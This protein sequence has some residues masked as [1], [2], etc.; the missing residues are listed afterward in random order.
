MTKGELKVIRSN[1]ISVLAKTNEQFSE[2]F[3]IIFYKNSHNK[4]ALF[5][6]FPYF[7]LNNGIVSKLVFPGGKKSVDALSLEETGSLTTHMVKYSHWEDGNTHFSQ[8]GK[9]YSK[10]RNLSTPLNEAAGHIFTIQLQG[11]SGFSK[12]H[13]LSKRL[14]RNKTDIDFTINSTFDA[15]KFS[16]W[17]FDTA[18]MVQNVQLGGPQMQIRLKDGTLKQGFALGPDD[19]IYPEAFLFLSCEIIPKLN[20]TDE[21]LLTFIGGFDKTARLEDDATFLSFI[22]PVTN[23]EELLKK[24]PT[25]DLS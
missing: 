3:K 2:L 16:G 21:T 4:S 8:D 9:V 15:L 11:L 7:N 5:I 25:I 17:W 24:L 18:G 20:M 6:T 13:D 19:P 14:S 1:E 12:R 22:Y 23:Y 10:I